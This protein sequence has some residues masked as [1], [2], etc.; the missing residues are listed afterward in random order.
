[1]INILKYSFC[2][3]FDIILQLLISWMIVNNIPH[4]F[5]CSEQIIAIFAYFTWIY[6]MWHLHNSSDGS[7][8][9]N[10][11][12][13]ELTG[14]VS[15]QFNWYCVFKY[16]LLFSNT[17]FKSVLLKKSETFF[18]V[19]KPAIAAAVM[20]N[21]VNHFCCDGFIPCNLCHKLLSESGEYFVESQYCL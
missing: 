4:F 9:A 2:S 7:E 17:D 15:L 13:S 14:V 1:M 3:Y 19:S 6:L 10:A 12:L 11:I 20:S 21:P 8:S 18:K 5:K 16:C